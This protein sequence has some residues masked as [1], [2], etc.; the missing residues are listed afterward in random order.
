VPLNEYGLWMAAGISGLVAY[1]IP[2]LA[3]WIGSGKCGEPVHCSFRLKPLSRVFF[4]IFAAGLSWTVQ[5]K[6]GTGWESWMATVLVWLLLVIALTDICFFLIPDVV[7]YSG[8][9]LFMSW[10]FFVDAAN[11]P[12][13]LAGG[14]FITSGLSLVSWISRGLGWGDVKLVAMASWVVEWPQLLLSIWFATLSSM[15][16]VAG[17]LRSRGRAAVREPLPF[18]PHL[19]AGMFLSLLCGD[20]LR[21]WYGEQFLQFFLPCFGS[22][23]PMNS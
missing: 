17:R 2:G 6:L 19:A 15:L 22:I 9:F 14:F 4:A 8:F 23:V 1:W 18:G 21:D 5:W 20:V 7:T 10:R 16:H 13:Y 11:M 3:Y 12:V